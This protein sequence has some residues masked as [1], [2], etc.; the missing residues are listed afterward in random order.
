MG[1][2]QDRSIQRSGSLLRTQPAITGALAGIVGGIVF[3]L[4]MA[5]MMPPML[6]MIGSL[7]GVPSLGVAV[8]LLF[9]AIIGAGFGIIFGSRIAG[10]DTAGIFGAGYGII[11]WVLGPLLIMPIW[12]GMGPMI[13]EAFAM[14]NILSL[15]GHLV[16][17]IITG[18]V[19]R[20]LT[21]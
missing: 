12:M 1:T 6:G 15:V 5:M 16:Y 19:F 8:H 9:S 3:G 11:W 18:I 2:P 14:P 20:A 21:R 7:L 13:T 4:M 17:G 10:W